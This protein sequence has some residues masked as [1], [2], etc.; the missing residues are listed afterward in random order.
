[1]EVITLS[2]RYAGS[3]ISVR[4]AYDVHILR[5]GL[6]PSVSMVSPLNLQQFSAELPHH[7]DSGKVEYVLRGITNCFDIGFSHQSPLISALKNKASA[8]AHPE[9]V[10]AYLHGEES[11]GWVSG[12]FDTSPLPDLH[13]RG[14]GVIPKADQ[15][16]KWHSILNLSSPHN[17]SVNDG[18]DPDLFSL[19]YIK[20]DDV[21]AMVAKLG[22]VP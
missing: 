18:T 8:Y 9:V 21:V 17:S 11:F 14:F 4:L 2:P 19:Q 20:F 22:G 16:R 15:P 6:W 1:M 12:P 10:D 3:L 13:I 5:L 7:L